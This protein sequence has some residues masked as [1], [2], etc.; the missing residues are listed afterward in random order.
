MFTVHGA[1]GL[2]LFSVPRL[3]A[4]W[5]VGIPSIIEVGQKNCNEELTE[6]L[7]WVFNS[8]SIKFFMELKC[9]A[10]TGSTGPETGNRD[11]MDILPIS[12]ALV[13]PG[14]HHFCGAAKYLKEQNSDIFV[15]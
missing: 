13:E 2:C 11:H 12:I 6:G 15:L 5:S 8:I 4:R 3:S 10:I 14:W 7:V 9:E 1:K